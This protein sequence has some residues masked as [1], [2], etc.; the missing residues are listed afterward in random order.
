MSKI[1]NSARNW[2]ALL[3]FS[4]FRKK[5]SNLECDHCF[6]AATKKVVIILE[7]N[8]NIYF[9]CII[10]GQSFGKLFFLLKFEV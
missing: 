6:A 4:D 8:Y 1:L 10:T 5:S 9:M 7:Y 2:R 3:F